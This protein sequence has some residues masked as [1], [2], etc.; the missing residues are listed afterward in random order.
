MQY[1]ADSR[2][3]L[4]DLRLPI[5][6][7]GVLEPRIF[8]VMWKWPAIY[9]VLSAVSLT[10]VYQGGRDSCRNYKLAKMAAWSHVFSFG[11]FCFLSIG[12]W[13]KWYDATA[14]KINFWITFVFSNVLGLYFL[15]SSIGRRCDMVYLWT[16]LQVVAAIQFIVLVIL[17][18]RRS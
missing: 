18:T 5:T 6:K 17:L 3:F 4:P 1:T 9:F 14:S 13:K 8:F 2:N 10:L 16:G 12:K 15:W 7:R 11:G